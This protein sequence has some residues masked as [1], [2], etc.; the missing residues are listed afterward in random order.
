VTAYDLDGVD[1]VRV[2]ATSGQVV[3]IAEDR[4]DV[5]VDGA[6]ALRDDATLT[7]RTGSDS[8]HVRVPDGCSVV[9]GSRSGQIELRGRFG[10]VGASSDSGRI[11][12]GEARSVDVR[13]ASGAVAVERAT[14]ACR[15]RSQSGR[16]EVIETADL[17]AHTES[18]SIVADSAMGTVRARTTSGT[19]EVGIRGASDVAAE[20]IDGT[21]VV[22]LAS[23]LG[24]DVEGRTGS[25]GIDNSAP[26]G[27]D[28]RIA[29]RSVS[30]RIE[31]RGR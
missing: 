23:G 21:I 22:Q 16:I 28:C 25:G 26:P 24:A 17:H 7:V 20:S 14:E 12:I 5:V 1:L 11:S 10:S 18:G 31:V 15:A 2:S 8:V 19:V 27:D 9:V 6:V 30:G 13:T 3:V 29:A 4:R